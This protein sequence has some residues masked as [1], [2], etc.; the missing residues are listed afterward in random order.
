MW[1]NDTGI[2]YYSSRVLKTIAEC[3]QLLYDDGL[4]FRPGST[5]T[6]PQA[7][8]EYRAD[9]D[10][11]LDHIGVGDWYGVF[12]PDFKHYRNYGRF[13]RI[14]IADILGITDEELTRLHYE[15]IPRLRG[16]AYHLMVKY[17]NGEDR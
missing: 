15:N 17:L 2:Y 3:Y 7:I 14:V 5:L 6:D 10:V 16:Y 8:A 9:F 13:Q 4:S 1:D 11:A 12:S